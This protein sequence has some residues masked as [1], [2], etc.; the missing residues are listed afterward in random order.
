MVIAH[1]RP[2]KN[3]FNAFGKIGPVY[4]E[5]P[6][7]MM[8]ENVKCVVCSKWGRGASERGCWRMPVKGS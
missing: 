6:E 4:I 3:F 5:H 8:R 1:L 2:K 7:R